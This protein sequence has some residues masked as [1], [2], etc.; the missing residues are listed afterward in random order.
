MRL[1]DCYG[2]DDLS[3]RFRRNESYL[4]RIKMYVTLS[5]LSNVSEIPG[6]GERRLIDIMDGTELLLEFQFM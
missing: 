1:K 5:V 3:R 4:G 6:D 2:S